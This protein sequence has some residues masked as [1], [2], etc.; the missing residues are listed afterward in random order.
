MEDRIS[1]D[2]QRRSQEEPLPDPKRNRFTWVPAAE[3]LD[4]Y[5]TV[6]LQQVIYI[7]L[8]LNN[9]Q[10]LEVVDQSARQNFKRVKIPIK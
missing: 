5:H 8:N 7:L 3:K 1:T 9:S 2:A 6:K 10:P 4:S